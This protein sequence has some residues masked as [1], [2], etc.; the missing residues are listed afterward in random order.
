LSSL[1]VL[2]SHFVAAAAALLAVSLGDTGADSEGAAEDIHAVELAHRALRLL[3]TV[4]IHKAVAG[5]PPREGVGRHAHGHN[6]E[7]MVLE[8][9]LDIRPLSGVEQIANVE[10][11]S[12]RAFFAR[13]LH[14]PV[15]RV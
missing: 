8:Q 4:Q 1:K 15:A 14:I 5:V 12:R 3:R 9:L 2:H 6:V 11:R 13:R 7:A 10:P